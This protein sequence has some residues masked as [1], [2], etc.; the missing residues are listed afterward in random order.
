MGRG[1][2]SLEQ[3]YHIFLTGVLVILAILVI[4]CLIRAIIGPRVADRIVSVNMMG[5][6]VIVIIAVLA[7]MLGEGYLAD[8]C[9]IYAMISFL[10][11]IVLTKVYTGVYLDGKMQGVEMVSTQNI[12]DTDQDLNTAGASIE[13]DEQENKT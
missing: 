2:E 3:V 5:T 6:M 4:F 12:H 7:L 1:I 9:I 10:A 13:S 8:I 11:V